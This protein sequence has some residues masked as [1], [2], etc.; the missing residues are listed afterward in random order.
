MNIVLFGAAYRYLLKFAVLSALSLISD[1]LPAAGVQ[2]FRCSDGSGGV[3]FRQT[4]CPSGD[5]VALQV[6]NPLMGWVRL[7]AG[8]HPATPVEPEAP[9]IDEGLEP[10]GAGSAEKKPDQQACW[11]ASTR[12]ARTER[13]LRK[14][15]KASKS[16]RLHQQRREQ[17]A[18][19]RRFCPKSRL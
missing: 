3:E 18:F 5:E 2:V 6:R 13:Q 14:G 17:E 12:L 15:Y 19:L 1:T 9:K 4:R 16:D 11:K 8:G 10:G 7:V